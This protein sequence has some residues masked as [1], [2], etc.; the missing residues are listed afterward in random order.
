MIVHCQIIPSIKFVS[1]HL[2]TRLE[3]GT[4][5]VNWNK[6]T[7]FSCGC[8]SGWFLFRT[9]QMEIQKLYHPLYHLVFRISSLL[10]PSLFVFS[11]PPI[12]SN[13]SLRGRRPKGTE[14][15]K[16][17]ATQATQTQGLLAGTMQCFRVIFSGKS[18]LQELSSALEVNFRVKISHRPG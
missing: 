14:R 9:G 4:V 15:G 6:T 1:T 7:G 3:R 13:P 2:Y 18:L 10:L 8:S 16:K 12:L 5:R 11:L 17:S